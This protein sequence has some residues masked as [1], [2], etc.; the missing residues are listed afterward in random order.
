M[1]HY[2]RLEGAVSCAVCFLLSMF[3]PPIF[4]VYKEGTRRE[5]NIP[6]RMGE[7]GIRAP[8]G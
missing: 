5:E 4:L 6:P 8:D 1:I 7:I 3:M 2:F